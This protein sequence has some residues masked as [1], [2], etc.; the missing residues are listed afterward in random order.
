MYMKTTLYIFM[1][2][3]DILYIIIIITIIFAVF[4]SV[5]YKVPGSHKCVHNTDCH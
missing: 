5:S 2:F 1:Y 4:W 3:P